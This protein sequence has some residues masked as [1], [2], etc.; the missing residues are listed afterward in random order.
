[1]V[2]C[3]A[4]RGRGIWARS[5]ATRRRSGAKSY[6]FVRI[7]KEVGTYDDGGK[8]VTAPPGARIVSV[9]EDA[10]WVGEGQIRFDA[11]YFGKHGDPGSPVAV[12]LKA[13][14]DVADRIAGERA[15]DTPVMVVVIA[16]SAEID[17]QWFLPGEIQVVQAGVPH[18]DLVVGPEGTTLLFLFAQRSGL[19]PKFSD[20]EDQERFEPLQ[21][22][23]EAAASG[24]EE[25]P[26]VLLPARPTYRARRGITVTDAASA[27]ERRSEGRTGGPVPEGMLRTSVHDAALPWGPP[28]LNAR[29]AMIVLGDVADKQAPTVGVINVAPGPG[30]R[31]RGRHIHKAD[32]VN[33]VIEGALYMDGI[34]LRAGEAKVVDADYEYGDG[35]AGPE[36][37]RFLEVWSAQEGAEPLFT[38]PD[39][40]AYF[41][42]L[43]AQGHLLSRRS[44][45]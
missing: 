38:D 44:L 42:D 6:P 26:I 43:K 18:G 27:E 1:V 23:V 34:W 14:R 12:F 13:G 10:H 3:G 15:H 2:F 24:A 11:L 39:D 21:A 45:A 36:G 7:E 8:N 16:G 20:P 9:H 33:L 22:A 40:Q 41:E 37:V 31:L 19:I 5:L 28:L 29:T 30:D 25:R 32:A 4:G 17:G 35:L